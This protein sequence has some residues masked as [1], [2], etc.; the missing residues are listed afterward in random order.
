MNK[1]ITGGMSEQEAR[2]MLLKRGISALMALAGSLPQKE[3]DFSKFDD[4]PT[5][6]VYHNNQFWNKN[7]PCILYSYSLWLK[8]DEP[9]CCDC[10]DMLEL[11]TQP[12]M[13]GYLRT[14][15]FMAWYDDKSVCVCCDKVCRDDIPF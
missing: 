1:A 9:L 3:P 2:E 7:Y 14:V 4:L 10:C 13:S 12:T 5:F 6:S 11:F 8:C 15:H